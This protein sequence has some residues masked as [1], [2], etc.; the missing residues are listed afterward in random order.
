[1]RCCSSRTV[2]EASLAGGS[3]CTETS[4]LWPCICGLSRTSPAPSPTS[5]CGPTGENPRD[6]KVGTADV[7]LPGDSLTVRAGSPNCAVRSPTASCAP[8]CP[9]PLAPARPASSSWGPT[10]CGV[11]RDCAGWGGNGGAG[12]GAGVPRGLAAGLDAWDSRDRAWGRCGDPPPFLPPTD[13]T[14]PAAAAAADARAP[15]GK[16]GRP[17]SPLLAGRSAAGL[18]G[19]AGGA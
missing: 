18:A 6:P 17:P 14:G 19:A 11:S 7:T 1:M 5:L 13:S 12:A 2:R 8:K 9:V 10:A 15:G 3:V 4:L 16:L